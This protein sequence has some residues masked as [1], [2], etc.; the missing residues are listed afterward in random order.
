MNFLFSNSLVQVFLPD[1]FSFSYFKEDTQYSHTV[2]YIDLMIIC[3]EVTK[4]IIATKD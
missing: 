3:D 2:K 1:G 4:E